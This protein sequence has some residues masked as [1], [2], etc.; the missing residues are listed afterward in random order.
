MG[1]RRG[2]DGERQDNKYRKR[3]KIK[4]TAGERERESERINGAEKLTEII[5]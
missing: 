1:R 2:S 3:P 4:E 5:L